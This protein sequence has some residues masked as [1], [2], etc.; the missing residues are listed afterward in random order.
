MLRHLLDR[1]FVGI[2]GRTDDLGRP[3]VYVT[4]NRFLR[5]FGLPRIEDLPALPEADEAGDRPAT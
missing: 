3:N 1:D 5:A 4:T 2:G